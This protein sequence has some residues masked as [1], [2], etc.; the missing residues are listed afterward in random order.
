MGD[1]SLESQVELTDM[2]T[3]RR[4]TGYTPSPLAREPQIVEPAAKKKNRRRSSLNQSLHA[5]KANVCLSPGTATVPED[6]EL[7][8]FTTAIPT[9]E[10]VDDG[11][12]SYEVRYRYSQRLLRERK[13]WKEIRKDV[14]NLDDDAFIRKYCAVD[15]R[16]GP[17]VKKCFEEAKANVNKFLVTCVQEKYGAE[18]Q[19]LEARDAHL[20]AIAEREKFDPNAEKDWEDFQLLERMQELTA[21]TA[22]RKIDL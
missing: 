1:S 12:P 22:R 14:E 7:P 15:F 21:F 4:S 16:E 8:E 5:L 10:I 20:R 17:N 11:Q 13:Q 19:S 18:V 9:Q 3:R 6:I 2:S